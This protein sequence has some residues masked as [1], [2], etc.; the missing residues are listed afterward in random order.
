MISDEVK[1]NCVQKTREITAKYVQTYWGCAQSSFMGIVDGLKAFGIEI[2]TLEVQES[3]FKGLVG[4]SGGTGNMGWG[5]C[6]ALAGAAFTIS[7]VSGVGREKQL[8]D[9]ENRRIAFDNAALTI[10]QKFLDEFGGVTCR[11]VTWKRWG[12]WYDSWN[13][14]AK[15]LFA[16]EERERGCLAVDMCTIA[17]AAGWAVE[18]IID[19]LNNPRTLEQAKKDFEEGLKQST[20]KCSLK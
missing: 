11:D 17:L 20:T 9:K 16:K 5:N 3:A 10:G 15:A 14:R 1:R 6:G 13:P 18:Y 2:M 19:I 12:K 7:Y 4:L 8:E